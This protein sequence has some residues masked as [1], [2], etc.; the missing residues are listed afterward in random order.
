MVPDGLRSVDARPKAP[1]IGSSCLLGAGADGTFGDSE[2]ISLSI[3]G[4]ANGQIKSSS[5]LVI[6]S[7]KESDEVSL[8]LEAAH[9][10]KPRKMKPPRIRYPINHTIF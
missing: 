3:N 7:K 4:S 8:P 2:N 6:L 5:K 1:T 9:I 10:P